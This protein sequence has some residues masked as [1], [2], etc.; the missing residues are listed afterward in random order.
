MTSDDVLIDRIRSILSRR[1][2]YSERRMFGSVCFMINGNMCVGTWNGSLIVRLDKKDHD[3]TL[4]EP[5]TRPADMNGRVMRGWALVESAG[6]ESNDHLTAW[7]DRPR[8]LPA[9]FRQSSNRRI[10]GRGARSK[11]TGKEV[12]VDRIESNVRPD[13]L[14]DDMYPFESRFFATPSGHRMH[15]VDDSEGESI[16]FVHSNPAWSFEFRHLIKGLRSK[17]RC[18]VN[19]RSPR[20]CRHTSACARRETAA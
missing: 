15:F 10:R 17:F 4:A 7:V 20:S 8:S 1:E 16:V 14:S 6:I 9:P 13:W 18:V 11:W 2:G 3:E 12:L 19:R 5:H